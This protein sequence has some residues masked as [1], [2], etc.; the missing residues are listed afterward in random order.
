LA[1]APAGASPAEL[2]GQ[3]LYRRHPWA[4]CIVHV[5]E[6]VEKVDGRGSTMPQSIFARADE[7]I[8]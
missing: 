1:F 6:A 4:G 3:V 2:V 5:H 8:E 7:V